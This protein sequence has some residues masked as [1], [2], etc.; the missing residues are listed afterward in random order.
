MH[1]REKSDRLVLPA[2]L[3]NNPAQ[4]GAE[5]V[6][7]RGLPEG[8]TAGEPRPGLGAGLGVS[9]DLDRVRRVA[10]KD[11]DVRFTALLHHVTV[12]RLGEAYRASART[13]PLGLMGSRGGTTAL[14]SKRTLAIYTPGFMEGRT[15]RDRL[16]GCSYR[17]PMGG[18]GRSG[19]LR[20]RTRSSRGRW[21]RC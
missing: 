20:W 13:L 5:V 21:S 2:K 1:D 17:S 3:P 16:A 12:D 15:G 9:S 8:N 11:R 19:S 6:E 14:I 7:G 10:R 18:C 4:A